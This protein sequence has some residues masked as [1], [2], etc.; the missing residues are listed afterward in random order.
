MNETDFFLL[1][2]LASLVVDAI[3]RCFKLSDSHQI[4]LIVDNWFT[5]SVSF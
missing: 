3:Q 5:Q 2:V 4:H 1:G